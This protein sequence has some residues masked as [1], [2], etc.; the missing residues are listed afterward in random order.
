VR[1]YSFALSAAAIAQL[2]TLLPIHDG[3]G[4]KM[5]PLVTMNRIFKEWSGNPAKDSL[6][7]MNLALAKQS[8][9]GFRFHGGKMHLILRR[10][11]GI[12]CE[13][14]NSSNIPLQLAKV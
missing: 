11:S 10:S 8:R 13:N 2:P 9:L 5:I 3:D 4:E 6:S 12:F 1:V 14:R 7:Q